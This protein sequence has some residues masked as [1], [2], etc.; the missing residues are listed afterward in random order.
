M[1]HPERIKVR[2]LDCQARIFK[3]RLFDEQRRK[4]I[5]AFCLV[6]SE[7]TEAITRSSF[8]QTHLEAIQVNPSFL[9]I[10]QYISFV[11]PVPHLEKTKGFSKTF[12]NRT[13][14]RDRHFV[15]E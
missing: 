1:S 13:R 7:E 15:V 9:T 12:V 2:E 3:Q 4:T 5:R 14:W 8:F 6:N 11:F 10:N